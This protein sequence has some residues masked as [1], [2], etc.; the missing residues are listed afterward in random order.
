MFPFIP[1]Q[2]RLFIVLFGWDY[3]KDISDFFKYIFHSFLFF[4]LF[5][6]KTS[7]IF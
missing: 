3:K 6:E 5:L 2:F 7:L 4:F 1:A